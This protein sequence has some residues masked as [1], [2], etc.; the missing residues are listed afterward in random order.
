MTPRDP[1]RPKPKTEGD[2]IGEVG[3]QSPGEERKMEDEKEE[4]SAEEEDEEPVYCRP[5]KEP[6]QPTKEEMDQHAITHLPFRRWCPFCVKGKAKDDPHR[7]VEQEVKEA[8]VPIISMDYMY[9]GNQ[10]ERLEKEEQGGVPTVVMR[11]NRSRVT[12]AHVCRA[13]GATDEWVVKKLAKDIDSLGYGSVVLRADNEPAIV[14]MQEA[15][16]EQRTAHTKPENVPVRDSRANGVAEKAIQEVAGQV[17]AMKLAIEDHIGE[18]MEKGHR[19]KCLQCKGA[20][21]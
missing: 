8:G 21:K 3:E 16:K 9:L 4:E 20:N 17:R 10:G 11:C 6:G 12:F 19:K 14:Q 7:K 1:I 13:K 2:G 5:C 18:A 15:I